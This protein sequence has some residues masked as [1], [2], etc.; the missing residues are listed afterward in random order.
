MGPSKTAAAAAAA[1]AVQSYDDQIVL[2]KSEIIYSSP[3]STILRLHDINKFIHSI[4]Q[5]PH[6]V[7]FIIFLFGYA[8]NP[9]SLPFLM[10]IATAVGAAPA[11]QIIQMEW[12]NHN[13]NHNVATMHKVATS[14]ST[15][16]R[17]STKW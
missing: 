9:V 4:D 15:S 6:W 2:H 17:P 5:V 10:A 8:F 11:S 3:I 13:D 14:L 1:A 12:A 16:W 7:E